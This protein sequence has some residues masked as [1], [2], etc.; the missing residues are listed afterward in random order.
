[1]SLQGHRISLN[2]FHSLSKRYGLRTFFDFS[3]VHT[4][5]RSKARVGKIRTPHGTIDTPTFVPVATNG[6]LKAV[7]NHL[8]NKE[9]NCFHSHIPWI[10]WPFCRDSAYVLQYISS[11]SAS[12]AWSC[13]EGR[14]FTQLYECLQI[15]VLFDL[16][17]FIQYPYPLIT[18]SG[19]FQVFF[20]LQS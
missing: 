11:S 16:I 18:D 6:V 2:C 9:G 14:R 19:G 17:V 12:W 7:D 13:G 1:M 5:S 15:P 8:A 3:I 4:S 10:I 20:R